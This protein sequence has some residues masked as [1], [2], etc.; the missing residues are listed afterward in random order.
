MK[1]LLFVFS[2]AMLVANQPAHAQG[3]R[4]IYGVPDGY[5]M[6][7]QELR[8]FF[9]QL[10]MGYIH[11]PL[12]DGND[13]VMGTFAVGYFP[14]TPIQTLVTLRIDLRFVARYF[15]SS[16]ELYSSETMPLQ[17]YSD[18]GMAGA[19]ELMNPWWVIGVI[20]NP[21]RVIFNSQ[22][23]IRDNDP[24]RASI[25]TRSPYS[26]GQYVLTAWVESHGNAI[27]L[28]HRYTITVPGVGVI[29]TKVID[30]PPISN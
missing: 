20:N 9:P 13:E 17:E 15:N 3:A 14:T 4:L 25:A 27:T 2:L 29:S 26:D 19:S 22:R 28:T 11:A 8:S 6:E 1:T 12:D 5:Y 10:F 23:F 30:T 16:G 24:M 18:D 7:G 21:P